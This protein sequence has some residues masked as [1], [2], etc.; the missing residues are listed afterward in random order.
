MSERKLIQVNVRLYEDDVE[1]VRK[2]ASK[3]RRPYHALLR[4]LLSDAVRRRTKVEVR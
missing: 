3:D 2:L 4:E 1:A